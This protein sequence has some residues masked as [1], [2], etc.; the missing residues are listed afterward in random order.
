MTIVVGAWGGHFYF[1][2]NERAQKYRVQII[3]NHIIYNLFKCK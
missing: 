3:A 2:P 1:I